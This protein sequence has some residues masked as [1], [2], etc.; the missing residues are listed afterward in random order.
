MDYYKDNN[1]LINISGVYKINNNSFQKFDFTNKFDSKYNKI[2]LNANFD[3][4]IN[5]PF[6]NFRT[7]KKVVN[8]NS[9][10]RIGKKYFIK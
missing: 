7:K 4:E 5:I 6:I 1:K 2:S 10:L 8:I 9:N 3:D